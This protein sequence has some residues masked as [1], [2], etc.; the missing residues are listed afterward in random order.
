MPSGV[1]WRTALHATTTGCEDPGREG[2]EAMSGTERSVRTLGTWSAALC[3]ALGVA[4][5]VAQIAEWLGWLGSGGGPHSR[6]TPAGLVVLLLPSLLLGPAF[7]ALTVAVHC[8]ADARARAWS[9]TAV[10]FATMY[11]TLT[12][13]VYYVQLAFVVPRVARGATEGIELLLFEPFDS[14]LYAVD[15]YGYS[16]MSLSTLFAA[17]VFRA[18]GL[19]RWI[20]RALIANGCLIPFLALQMFWPPLIW[21]G[22]LWAI[23]FPLASALLTVHFRRSAT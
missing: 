19:E 8:W 22:A 11:A 23:T 15:V 12:G 4:Y 6:S 20:R 17:A 16:L 21:G 13:I 18:E 5:S 2:E 14:F 3:L 10:V 7:V 1:A 9:L